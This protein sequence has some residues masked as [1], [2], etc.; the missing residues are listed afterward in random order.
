V[1]TTRTY[2]AYG[3]QAAT[4]GAARA[5]Y[6][7]EV[8]EADTGWYLL[9]ERT[10]SPT[11][12]RFLAA[13][14]YS[15]FDLGGINRYTYCGGDPVSR[16]DP[17]GHSWLGWLSA[18]QGLNMSGDVARSVSSASRDMGASVS[19]PGAMASTAAA[20]TD[21]ISVTSAI[22]SVALMTARRPRSG[23]LFGWTAM[24]TMVISG[25]SAL[26]AARKGSRA[27]RF[28]GQRHAGQRSG[29][30]E[31]ARTHTV[32]LVMDADVPADRLIPGSSGSPFLLRRW[33]RGSHFQN[34]KSRI[35]AADTSIGASN[36]TNLLANLSRKKRTTEVNLYTGAHGNPDGMNWNPETGARLDAHRGFFDQDRDEVRNVAPA[37]GITINLVDL[38]SETKQSIARRLRDDGVHVMSTCFGLSDEVVMESL[39]LS[40]V[41]VYDLTP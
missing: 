32:Q 26:P 22:D 6:A 10:Y 28:V 19:T 4:A 5:A 17:S 23:G 37:M 20:V 8:R 33:K 3:A 25:G 16:S 39:N 29:R 2:G 24:G 40:H 1:A 18:S 27:E 34:P 11:L 21:A 9:G 7:G 38:G 35:W 14:S 12:R 15:P 31:G 36:V 41:I 13:D 30:G